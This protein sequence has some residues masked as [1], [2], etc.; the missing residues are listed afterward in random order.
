MPDH[1]LDYFKNWLPHAL[2]ISSRAQHLT[3]QRE[4]SQK[5]E[6]SLLTLAAQVV[7]QEPSLHP[8]TNDNDEI[9]TSLAQFDFLS[10]LAAI[11][12]AGLIDIAAFH[13]N[14]AR[15]RQSRIQPVADRIISD[16]AMRQAIFPGHEDDD[17]AYSLL[18][19]GQIAH[20]E[21]LRYDGFW[22][23]DRT[24]VGQFIEAHPDAREKANA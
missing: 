19:M 22:G 18:K 23:W 9:I 12:D 11:D 14:W 16:P 21:A 3:E 6:L 15:F 5:V 1:L 10:N 7:E 13:T 20:R 8:D 17:L 2:V 4:N 24:S